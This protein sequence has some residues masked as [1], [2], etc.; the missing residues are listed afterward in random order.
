M[1]LRRHRVPAGRLPG[2]HALG[3]IGLHLHVDLRGSLS[4][5]QVSVKEKM[6]KRSSP[7]QSID[8]D[9]QTRA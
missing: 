3:S 1:G 4:G 5:C 8:R 9:G 7:D 2:G 6:Q